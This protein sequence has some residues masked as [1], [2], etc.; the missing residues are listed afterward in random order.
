MAQYEVIGGTCITCVCYLHEKSECRR[1]PPNIFYDP[2]E[3]DYLSL[4]PNTETDDSCAE[5]VNRLEIDQEHE[6]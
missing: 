5:Y 3:D 4:W 6:I 2:E 1:F